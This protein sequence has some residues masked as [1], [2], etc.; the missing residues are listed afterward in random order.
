VATGALPGI[1]DLNSFEDAQTRSKNFEQS[2]SLTQRDIRDIAALVDAESA[3]IAQNLMAKDPSLTPEQAKQLAGSHVIDTVTNRAA[4]TGRS[5]QSIINEN[6]QFSPLNGPRNISDLKA[7]PSALEATRNYLAGTMAT[8][9]YSTTTNFLNKEESDKKNVAGWGS[10]M[11]GVMGLPGNAHSYGQTKDW[12]ARDLPD[13]AVSLAPGID[14]TNNS[15][16]MSTSYAEGLLSGSIQPGP[17]TPPSAPARDWVGD[18]AP[19]PFG[20]S[21][22]EMGS[23]APAPDTFKAEAPPGDYGDYANKSFRDNG[24]DFG[25]GDPGFDI[26]GLN[27]D[28]EYGGKAFASGPDLPGEYGGKSFAAVSPGQAPA[29]FGPSGF[30]TGLGDDGTLEA[31]KSP[32][33]D[34]INAL[35]E[36]FREQ[37]GISRATNHANINLAPDFDAMNKRLMEEMSPQGPPMPTAPVGAVSAP[38]APEQ[39]RSLFAEMPSLPELQSVPPAP[40]IYGQAPQQPPAPQQQAPQPTQAIQPSAPVASGTP[41][42]RQA[43]ATGTPHVSE[44][45]EVPGAGKAIEMGANAAFG[46]VAGPFGLLNSVSGIFGGPTIGK[47]ARALYNSSDAHL[48]GPYAEN[49]Q[50]G[51]MS[52]YLGPQ[53]APQLTPEQQAMLEEQQQS[54]KVTP[55][56]FDHS[57]FYGSKMP[58]G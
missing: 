33:T 36:D 31:A 14:R 57:M 26:S 22:K 29:S 58:Y 50:P 25:I 49:Y 43:P 27:T 56:A 20:F 35:K 53:Q 10:Q 42:S 40:Q 44:K 34:Q 24:P 46:L 1:A 5:I 48:R 16:P 51:D 17:P 32:F 39:P 52:A 47:G 18:T 38:P 8:G 15:M 28:R 9:P 21:G 45:K 55:L 12:A 4:I 13:Y 54:S 37:Q 41:A 7:T 23:L 30:H 19:D 6:K 3:I 11:T 2:L